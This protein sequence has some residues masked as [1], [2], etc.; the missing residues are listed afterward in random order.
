MGFSFFKKKNNKDKKNT[1]DIL[2]NQFNRDVYPTALEKTVAVK[3]SSKK[4]LCVFGG[5]F[6]PMHRAHLD[7]AF[8]ACRIFSIDKILFMPSGDSY[9]KTGV[10]CAEDRLEICRLSVKEYSE[11]SEIKESLAA[12][13]WDVSDLEI[14]REGKTYT[15]ETIESLRIQFPEYDIYFLV[16]EDTLR[17]ME[18]W[19]EPQ[20]VF[21]GCIV[22]AAARPSRQGQLFDKNGH[23]I[24]GN[25]AYTG[26]VQDEFNSSGRSFRNADFE[27]IEDLQARLMKQYPA[28][29]HIMRFDVDMSSSAIKEDI[30]SGKDVSDRLMPTAYSFI[31]DKMLYR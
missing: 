13:E 28:E 19:K 2:Q 18:T 5:T 1:G 23:E 7:M 16:G 24:H 27:R 10:S 3:A 17:S 9:F 25:T 29:I 11:Q 31:V 12:C 15:Y 26:S 20:I 21:A 6:D 4:K 8:K 22:I 30:R 14:K